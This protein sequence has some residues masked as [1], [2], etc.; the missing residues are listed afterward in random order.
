M[1]VSRHLFALAVAASCAVSLHTG[2]GGAI[3]PQSDAGTVDA[4]DSGGGGCDAGLAACG[5]LCVDTSKDS[6]H[7]GSCS[8]ACAPDQA[9]V[10]GTCTSTIS[11]GIGQTK[12]GA[13]CVSTSTDPANCG[14]CGKV[15][16][17][18]SACVASTCSLACG[19]GQTLCSG[20]CV[21][22]QIDNANC[23]SCGAV[24]APDGGVG[25]QK[26]LCCG[27]GTQNCGGK[28]ID[29][30]SD[31]KNCGSCGNVCP[32]QSPGCAVGKCTNLQVL[33][34]LGSQTFY[35]I[36]VTGAMS[37]TNV[38]NACLAA[39]LTVGCSSTNCLIYT[40]NLCTPTQENSCGNPMLSLAGVIG[41]AS[42][43]KCVALDG[44]YQYMGQ[45]WQNGSACG[46]EGAQWCSTGNSFTNRWALCVQ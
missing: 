37:D 40:D 39:G 20:K 2:C 42:P 1:S 22:T 10:K 6:K 21:D 7:C 46:A 16:P 38:Y 43:S 24:C 14:G 5:A 26:G 33:G 45:K 17:N 36:P 29:T 41:C 15:C 30:L 23:G 4:G 8:N 18:G 44:V 34:T 28:C 27:G 9:C 11:C 19:G 31:P 3:A 32:V 13:I 12:C 25:C 35:K